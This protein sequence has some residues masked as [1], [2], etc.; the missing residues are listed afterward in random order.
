MFSNQ[1]KASSS[2]SVQII[3]FCPEAMQGKKRSCTKSGLGK[4]RSLF[5]SMSIAVSS[6]VLKIYTNELNT[7]I[8]STKLDKLLFRGTLLP[9][10]MTPM[11]PSSIRSCMTKLRSTSGALSPH[12]ATCTPRWTGTKLGSEQRE[13]TLTVFHKSAMYRSDS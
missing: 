8:T 1:N 10:Q 6:N 2:H 12:C 11:T 3:H 9:S 7:L 4:N 5:K 13:V